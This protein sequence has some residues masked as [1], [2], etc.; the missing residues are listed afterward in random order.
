MKSFSKKD[1]SF[2][3]DIEQY[4]QLLMNKINP[5]NMADVRS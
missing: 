5:Y 1:I 4:I 2:L 3:V